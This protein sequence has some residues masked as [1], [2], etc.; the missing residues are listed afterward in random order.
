MIAISY[1]VQLKPPEALLKNKVRNDES[2]AIML[3]ALKK[4]SEKHP[5]RRKGSVRRIAVFHK[6]AITAH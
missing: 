2:T 3:R 6:C 4:E 1:L 5:L